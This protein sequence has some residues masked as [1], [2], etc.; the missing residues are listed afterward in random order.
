MTCAEIRER[1]DGYARGEF[2]PR[3]DAAFEAHL[4]S[5]AACAALL[6]AAEPA[7]A[8]ARTLP[9]AVEPGANLWPGVRSRMDPRIAP[10]RRVPLPGWM[11]AAAAVLLVAV[12]S[13]VTALLLRQS[14]SRPT[15]QPSFALSA[16]EA[17]Y[18]SATADL[19]TALEGARGR[20]A[21]ATI[22]TIE[23]NLAVID[24]AL[25]ESRRALANDPDNTALEHLVVAAW[26]QKVDFLRRATALASE[27]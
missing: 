25:A 11:L 16:L 6:E 7:L 4:S 3:E 27:S 10:R 8:E 15:A 23:R 13:G 22:A 17:E 2:S 14:S 9:R 19:A 21:P 1:L 18:A 26:R 5:C 24:Q 12:S 20:L